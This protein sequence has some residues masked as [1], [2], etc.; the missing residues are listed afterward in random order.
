LKNEV[1]EMTLLREQD[2]TAILEDRLLKA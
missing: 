1:K 2:G